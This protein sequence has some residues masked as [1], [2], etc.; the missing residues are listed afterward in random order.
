MNCVT[1]PTPS[2]NLWPTK[3]TN[4]KCISA[5]SLR[6]PLLKNAGIETTKTAI[7]V[8]QSESQASFQEYRQEMMRKVSEAADIYWEYYRAQESLI[9]IQESVRIAEKILIDN[10]QRH[11][12]GKM[13]KT[14]VSGGDG[15]RGISQDPVQ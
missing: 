5:P 7:R 13:A 8:A 3:T 14:E 4:I 15:R 2:Q 11:R 6:Q 12:T 9:L 10:R 1:Y